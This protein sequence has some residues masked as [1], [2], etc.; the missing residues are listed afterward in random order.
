MAKHTILSLVLV[1]SM[2][3]AF[4]Q[5]ASVSNRA[6]AIELFERGEKALANK[7]YFKAQAHYTEA[8]RLDPK[9]AEAY[10]SRAIAREYL[11]ES[12]K[13]LTDF[14][15]YVDLRPEDSEALF[16]RAVL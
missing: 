14:N 4:G 2:S 16:N 8:V 1:L 15:I 5:V 11:G 3:L 12:A 9:Y 6:K 13:A 10:R 7:E